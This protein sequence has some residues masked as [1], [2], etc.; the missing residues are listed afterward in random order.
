MDLPCRQLTQ[1]LA[2][3]GVTMGC[4]PVH[5]RNESLTVGEIT[6]NKEHLKETAERM[7]QEI[8]TRLALQPSRI[9]RVKPWCLA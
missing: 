7:A 2:Q 3:C 1:F 4:F 5:K 6:R 9:H 8:E